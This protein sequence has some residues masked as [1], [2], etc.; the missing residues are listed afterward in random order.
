MSVYFIGGSPCAGKSTVAEIL[1][2]RCGLTCFKVDDHLERYTRMGAERGCPICGKQTELTPD[3]IWMRDPQLQCREELA[4]YREIFPFALADLRR[5]EDEAGI[6]TEGAA[7]LPCLMREAGVPG[8]RYIA[9][10]PT[11]AFQEFHYRRRDFVPLVLRDCTDRERAFRNWMER[12][13]LFAEEV[14]NQCRTLGYT[15]LLNDG[16]LPA[17]ALA[18]AVI[19]HFALRQ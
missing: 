17:A 16:S 19:R 15:S 13:A 4:F 18:D 3:Q 5:M 14:R 9:I 10:T 8:S 6:L 2:R 7:W 12:D 11:R 1:S